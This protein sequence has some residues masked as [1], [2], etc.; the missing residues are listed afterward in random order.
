MKKELVL[1]SNKYLANVAINYG[2][3][4]NLHWN[5]IGL[6]FKPVHE[7]LESLYDSMHEVLDEVAELLKM[8]G[9]YPLASFKEYLKVSEIVELESKDYSVKEALEI[10]LADIKVLRDNA[11][12]LRRMANV[13][14]DKDMKVIN[15][16][17][18]P[19]N[20]K[21]NIAAFASYIYKKETV[22]LIKQYLSEGNNPDAPGFFP[23]WLY[24]RKDMEA[25]TVIIKA[26]ASLRNE[27]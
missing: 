26:S 21:S 6:Q 25:M 5:V 13:L 11:L 1:K 14:V 2:K 23:S 27:Y 20:P 22:P 12:E 17:E 18:K 16:E 3:L 7:Y 10:A 15:M 8:N 9:E 24:Q 4:H 19:Q